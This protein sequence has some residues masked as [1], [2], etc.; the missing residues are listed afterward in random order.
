MADLADLIRDK[1]DAGLLPRQLSRTASRGY[2]DGRPCSACGVAIL[3][4][5]GPVRAGRQSDLPFPP[6]LL[7]ALASGVSTA[8]EAK[9]RRRVGAIRVPEARG[10]TPYAPSVSGRV[11]V[12]TRRVV[13]Q[14]EQGSSPARNPARLHRLGLADTI[15]VEMTGSL[16]G[17]TI[18]GHISREGHPS[19]VARMHKRADLPAVTA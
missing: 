5:T 12:S 9:G 8:R 7:R 11:A 3:P 19:L 13:P 6:R 4:R 18:D 10:S 2:G 16:K 14:T 17:R 1:L 15:D